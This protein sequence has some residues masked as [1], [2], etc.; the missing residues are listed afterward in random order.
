MC[1]LE[2]GCQFRSGNYL[3]LVTIP[4][5]SLGEKKKQKKPKQTGI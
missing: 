2:L 4:F 1:S 3:S 5:I